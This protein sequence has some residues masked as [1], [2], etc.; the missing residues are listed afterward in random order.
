MDVDSIEDPNMIPK[1]L[2]I[3]L[4]GRNAEEQDLV[5]F[6]LIIFDNECGVFPVV[7]EG[8]QIGWTIFVSTCS[9]LFTLLI[10]NDATN[11]VSDS[12]IRSIGTERSGY[13]ANWSLPRCRGVDK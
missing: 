10:R 1:G 3:T 12:Y 11:I 13:S 7:L 4:A 9:L 5:D 8:Q 6:W 2:Q